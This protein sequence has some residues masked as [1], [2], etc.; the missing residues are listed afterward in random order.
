[1]WDARIEECYEEGEKRTGGENDLL[2]QCL[3][4]THVER[5][6]EHEGCLIRGQDH[7]TYQMD[8]FM[9]AGGP[10]LVLNHYQSNTSSGLF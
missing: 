6:C 5:R 10:V 4:G 8:R 9:C 1:M 3:A 2:P 7:C